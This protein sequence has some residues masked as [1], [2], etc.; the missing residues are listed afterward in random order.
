MTGA[1]IM[2]GLAEYGDMRVLVAEDNPV[3]QRLMG[4]MLQ[5]LGIHAQFVCDGAAALAEVQR[6]AFDLILMDIAMPVMDGLTAI[7][8]IRELEARDKRASALIYVVSSQYEDRDR[9]ASQAAGANGHLAKPL[10]V[11][12][13][14][15]AVEGGLQ[16][17]RA[18]PDRKRTPT[19]A[20]ATVAAA[21]RRGGA[22]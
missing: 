17:M 21:Q 14:L 20:R 18:R 22:R 15:N 12:L 11:S 4:A 7:R 5:S 1:R 13:F 2:Q 8:L 10:V 9:L 6:G 16:L 3:N 19:A